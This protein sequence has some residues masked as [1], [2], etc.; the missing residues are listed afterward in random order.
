MA[1]TQKLWYRYRF[2]YI[3]LFI[4]EMYFAVW[5]QHRGY[6]IIP[7]P[8]SGLLYEATEKGWTNGTSVTRSSSRYEYLASGPH[9]FY[10]LKQNL[11]SCESLNDLKCVDG[12]INPIQ[13]NSSLRLIYL[14]RFMM[15]PSVVYKIMLRIKLWRTDKQMLGC[16]QRCFGFDYPL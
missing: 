5:G 8:D 9:I 13:L 1:K 4:I 3:A 14:W 2:L 16:Q 15:I 11:K 6:G 10:L 7:L 12:T